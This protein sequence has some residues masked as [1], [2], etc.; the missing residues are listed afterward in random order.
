MDQPGT[1]RETILLELKKQLSDGC[2]DFTELGAGT[3]EE[4]Q[5]TRK[6]VLLW[7]KLPWKMRLRWKVF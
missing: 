1:D 3:E 2:I 5:K 6:A 7:K 4:A